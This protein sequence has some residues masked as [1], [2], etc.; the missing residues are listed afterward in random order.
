MRTPVILGLI[1]AAVGVAIVMWLRSQ[2]TAGPGARPAPG[3]GSTAVAGS[4]ATGG[5]ATPTVRPPQRVRRLGTEE[6]RQLGE[7]IAVARERVRAGRTSAGGPA[8]ALDDTIQLE[9][10]GKTVQTALQ[11]AIPILAECYGDK[12]SGATATVAMTMI[13]D[14]DL[15][16]VIDTDAMKDREGK[17]LGRELDDCLRTAIESLALPPLDVGGRL[18]L[19]YSFVFD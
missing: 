9:Q 1:V 4:A 19:E 17:P 16:T 2:D 6:R 8:P 7:R 12:P 14:P 15:G 18:P 5:A 11:E 13:S 3:S 10:V